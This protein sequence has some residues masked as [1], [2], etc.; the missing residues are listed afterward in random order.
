MLVARVRRYLS[1]ILVT[2]DMYLHKNNQFVSKV[3]LTVANEW[4]QQYTTISQRLAGTVVLF[5]DPTNPSGNCFQYRM[6][7]KEV[8][9][10]T[11]TLLPTY[12]T[13]SDPHWDW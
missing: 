5:P 6:R 10:L 13:E 9:V 4:H 12:N 3:S 7:E 8:R 1:C 2:I 11:L